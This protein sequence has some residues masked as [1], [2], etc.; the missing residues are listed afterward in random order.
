MIE[1]FG[2]ITAQKSTITSKFQGPARDVLS[3]PVLSLGVG[4]CCCS[5]GGGLGLQD[6]MYGGPCRAREL[7]PCR[8]PSWA[9]HTSPLGTGGPSK[10][11]SACEEGAREGAGD[12]RRRA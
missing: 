3:Q 11:M 4:F 7:T 2:H 1:A 10:P 6:W 9:G 8:H 5:R 12:K